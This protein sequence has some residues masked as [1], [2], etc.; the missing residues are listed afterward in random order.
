MLGIKDSVLASARLSQAFE[1]VDRMSNGTVSINE[2]NLWSLI[3]AFQKFYDISGSVIELTCNHN[4]AVWPVMQYLRT[5][6]KIFLVSSKNSVCV[7]A[8]H[9]LMDSPQIKQGQLTIIESELSRGDWIAQIPIEFLGTFRWIYI[10]CEHSTSSVVVSLA[11]AAALAGPNS[12]LCIENIWHDVPCI[13][14]GLDEW[15]VGNSKW[16][17]ILQGYNKAYLV[18]AMNEIDWDAIFRNLPAIFSRFY[19]SMIEVSSHVSNSGHTC[20]TYYDCK[21]HHELINSHKEKH[22]FARS[23]LK[24]NPVNYLVGS[25][26]NPAILVFGNCQMKVVSMALES[27]IS[28]LGL[29]FTVRYVNEVHELSSKDRDLLLGLATRSDLIIYQHVRNPRYALTSSELIE[30]CSNQIQCISVPSI[31]YPCYWPNVTGLRTSAVS[32]ETQLVDSII[33]LLLV[34]GLSDAEVVNVIQD[35]NL[36]SKCELEEWA[37]KVDANLSSREVS[38]NVSIPMA[39][40]LSSASQKSKIMYTVNHPKKN[41]FD[42]LNARLI[43]ALT[44]YYEC[45]YTDRL[46]MLIDGNLEVEYDMSS[47]DFLDIVPLHSVASKWA[48][49]IPVHNVNHYRYYRQRFSREVHKTTDL[50][51]EVSQTRKIVEGTRD[52]HLAYNLERIMQNTVVP[53]AIYP[54]VEQ[55][56]R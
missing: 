11:N 32:L 19:K 12:I 20:F 43:E 10:N 49:P 36:Y 9:L 6:E 29:P 35:P 37:T 15:L 3:F 26:E 5:N 33:Y 42:Y 2:L 54:R 25:Q 13:R 45:I 38:N 50:L 51:N 22:R 48:H 27:S 21:N 52:S 44:R 1:I 40:F 17:L 28:L 53:S 55:A 8:S 47:I 56:I 24:I 39:S 18:S 14:K 16:R 46:R 7:D 41:V 4:I 23:D 34:N 30:A 31:Y